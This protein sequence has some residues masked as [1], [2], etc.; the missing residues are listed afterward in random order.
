MANQPESP[1]YDAGVYQLET[2]DPVLG[3]VAGQSNT[4]LL[5]LANRTAYLK[6]HLDDLESGAFIPAPVA[7]LAS[8]AF[9]GTPTA[10]TAAKGTNTTALATT[11]FVQQATGGVLS[12][13]VAGG[14]NVTLTAAEAGNA[15]LDLTGA[16]LADI[17]VIVP[18]SPTRGWTVRNRTTGAFTITI[19]TAAGTGVPV[20]QGKQSIVYTDGTNVEYANNDYDLTVYAPVDSPSFTG[21]PTAPPPAQFDDSTRIITSEWARVRGIELYGEITL[22]GSA[23]LGVTD[24]GR[25]IVLNGLGLT[26]TLPDAALLPSGACIVFQGI[27][28][29]T[30]AAAGSDSITT[31]SGTT[32]SLAVGSGSTLMLVRRANGWR[33]VAGS[34]TLDTSAEFAN[35]L[36]S[37]GSQSM[38]GGMIMKWGVVA[39]LAS[40]TVT[41]PVAFP[42]ATLNVQVSWASNVTSSAVAD[43]LGGYSYT[44]SGFIMNKGVSGSDRAWFAIGH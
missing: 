3:G 14:A 4:P 20:T 42:T 13:S 32:T 18:T 26:A 44:A 7:P 21:T 40:S 17:A 5:N 29:A 28:A 33:A 10:P 37:E 25:T 24:V 39:G 12:K 41:Y 30:V 11:A 16:L 6:A 43:W 19:K 15:I 27:D 2:V 23:A 1:T 9:T 34:A 38:P 36:A 8:P 31:G 22:T 35:V